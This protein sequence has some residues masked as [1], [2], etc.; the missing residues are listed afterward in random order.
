M[1]RLREDCNVPDGPL[2]LPALGATA[3]LGS[4][5]GTF[6]VSDQGSAQYTI[7]IDVPPGR[8]GMQPALA[9]AYDSQQG[10]GLLGVGFSLSGI[11]SVVRCPWTITDDGRPRPVQYDAQDAIC[12]GGTRLILL[13]G[14][15]LEDAEYRTNPDTFAKVV[16]ERRGGSETT[17][18]VVREKDGRIVTYGGTTDSLITGKRGRTR[19]WVISSVEDRYGNTITYHYAK[20]SGATPGDPDLT[21]EFLPTEIRYG[22]HTPSGRANDRFVRFITTT[23]TDTTQGFLWGGVGWHG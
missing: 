22:A 13:T 6:A 23:R 18:F 17:A 3:P 9:V 21:K 15:H 12:L 16:A 10:N 2:T 5:P 7:P 19:V 20:V 4:A 14:T 8:H 11:S 1:Q